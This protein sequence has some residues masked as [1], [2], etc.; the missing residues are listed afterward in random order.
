MFK[1]LLTL[2]LAVLLL[3][4]A[5]SCRQGGDSEGDTAGT[6]AESVFPN[7][8]PVSE[9]FESLPETTEPQPDPEPE[10]VTVPHGYDSLTLDGKPCF[11]G[12]IHA[13]LKAADYIL[14]IPEGETV[15]SLALT[16]WIGFSR[17]VDSF[18]YRI[19]GGEAVYGLFSTYT[20]EEIRELGGDYALRFAVTV[21]LFELKPGAHTI[22]LLA[23]FL[24]G[25]EEPIL[26]TLTISLEGV[27][28]DPAIRYHSSLTHIGGQGANGSD[29]YVGRGGS[30]ERGV[31][32]I[33][34]KLNGH[35][36]AQNGRLKISGWLALEG[37]VERYVWSA[38]G[39]T[40]YTAQSSSQSG[41]P[42]EGHFASLGYENAAGNALFTD[43]T[44]DLSPCQ[45]RNI[46]VTVGGVPKNSPDKV[47]PFVTITGLDIPFR[48]QDIDF[49]FLS[50]ADS[51]P[52]GTEL[53][54]SDLSY[55]FDVTYGAG[56][57][58]HVNEHDGALCYCYSGIH[59]LQASMS[60]R[61]ALTAKLNAMEGVS[62]L[63]VRAT[64]AVV[65]VDEVPLTLNNFYE[66]D[67]LGLCGGAGIYAKL[68]DGTLTVVIKSL[69]PKA[70]YRI[71]N[72]TYEFPAQGTSLTMADN[73][74]R[75]YILVDGRVITHITIEGTKEYPEHFA[76]VSPYILFA[77]TVSIMMPN[78]QEVAV[79]NP[80][81]AA[82]C[83]SHCGIAIR[84]GTIHFS[85]LSVI[86][87]ADSGAPNP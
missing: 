26:D 7:T 10:A 80:L 68:A 22:S 54:A 78:R 48:A 87:F 16:G 69:D 72:N 28:V 29:A 4:L 17:A 39:L 83:L 20:E 43:L 77:S 25:T 56:N 47:V 85:E 42:S 49:S 50:S 27:T 41:E 19:D 44:L 71:R 9:P 76:A 73:G 86:P 65:S 40:W 84:G 55:L 45:S 75:V 59:S 14:R 21:P 24:D 52:E 30:V 62:F 63:F 2:C 46:A 31:D 61:F 81:V 38:D 79:A 53:S 8:D 3:C 12:D 57:L 58:R 66:T 60:G 67:G 37:G 32:V 70:A 11:E 6:G 64:R 5:A 74:D 15:T 33:D 35:T 18:G 36:V 82:T 13:G 23:R 51:N 34:A 1:R